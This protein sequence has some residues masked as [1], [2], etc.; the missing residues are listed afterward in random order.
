MTSLYE[1]AIVFGRAAL[2]ADAN[3]KRRAL[4]LLTERFCESSEEQF[5]GHLRQHGQGAAMIRIRIER[6]TGKAHR[7]AAAA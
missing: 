1:S 4:R 5:E 2:V 3:E 7:A 6:I